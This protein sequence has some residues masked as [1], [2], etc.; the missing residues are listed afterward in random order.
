MSEKIYIPDT[1][2][3]WKW[4][5]HL[6]THYAEVKKESAA[7]LA[8]FGAFSPRAQYAFDRCDF[9]LLASFAYPLANKEHLRSG[10]DLMNFF[11][12]FDEYSDVS[13]VEDVQKQ[14]DIIMDATR[15]PHKQRPEGEWIGGEIARQFW[16]RTIKNAS[17]QSQK[18]FLE[19]WQQYTDSVVQQAADRTHS[20]IRD[21]DSYLD[22]RRDT[23]GAK[24]SFALLELGM[25]LPD[26]VINHPVV[27]DL[28]LWTIDM[29]CIG[30]DIVSYNLEQA[31]G[32]DGHNIVT[33]VMNQLK[34][35]VAGA[36]KWIEEYHKGLEDKFNEAFD[37]VPKWVTHICIRRSAASVA[38]RSLARSSHHLV[39]HDTTRH[40]RDA[41]SRWRAAPLVCPLPPFM[42]PP[43]PDAAHALCVGSC[44]CQLARASA[45]TM[46]S[47][48]LI[49][50]F[51]PRDTVTD[52]LRLVQGAGAGSYLPLTYPP[53]LPPRRCRSASHKTSVSCPTS[54]ATRAPSRAA[55]ESELC[56]LGFVIGKANARLSDI[57]LLAF[58]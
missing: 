46:S 32:D 22:V 54:P 3:N 47:T 24:P 23:I 52:S 36:M 57:P 56:K 21:I 15:N 8:S 58:A 33:I 50:P 18:R 55:H 6:N 37:K 25:D 49:P 17:P 48:E 53:N 38:V 2:A 45:N 16:E 30:N 35:D 26:E 29:L 4:P 10:C 41:S 20:H 5:R 11:F 7:W 44:K 43:P 9:N 51:S 28:S 42:P 1:L 19:T 39:R 40:R 13:N 27:Q 12:V 31:R 14:A 34:T